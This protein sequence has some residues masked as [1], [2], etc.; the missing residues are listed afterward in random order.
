MKRTCDRV[1]S[2]H[3]KPRKR[4]PDVWVWRRRIAGGLGIGRN[5][6]VTIGP[7]TELPTEKHAW[8]VSQERR[9]VMIEKD[10]GA[11]FQNLIERYKSEFLDVRHS[12]RA[13]YLSRLNRYIVP[14]WGDLA[15]SDIKPLEVERKINTLPLSKKT[16]SHIK[17]QMHRLF[18]FAMKCELIEFQRNPMLSVEIRGFRRRVRKKQVLTPERFQALLRLADLRLQVMMVLACCLGLRPSE[19]LGLQWPDV[20]FNRKLLGVS[21]SITGCHVAATKTEDS[22]DEIF[23]DSKI[24]AL[25]LR[26][27][28][29]CPTTA[30][31]WLFPNVDTGRPFHAD[32]LRDDHLHPLGQVIGIVNL[33]WYAFRHTYRTLL[34]DL[35]TPVGVQQKLMRHSDIRTTMNVYGSAYEQSKRQANER[36]AGKLLEIEQPAAK[37]LMQ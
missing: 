25:L 23:L 30:E 32:S 3:R 13:S 35:G 9:R 19:F 6:S 12:T 10:R 22:E 27:K 21:R 18:E 26:W 20:N 7:V 29:E 36:V 31:Q 1:G 24:V 8:A 28:D 2:M 17:A 34:D 16:K 4:G 14:L 11:T 5:L 33:G 37:Q 15:I